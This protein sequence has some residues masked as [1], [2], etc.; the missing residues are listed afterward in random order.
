MLPV[1]VPFVLVSPPLKVAA[2]VKVL[3]PVTPNVP[4]TVPLPLIAKVPP[5]K[6]AVVVML[7]LVEIVP[8][9]VSI[10][11]AVRIPV[12]VMLPWT[13]VGNVCVK[14]GTLDPLV[15]RIELAAE[16]VA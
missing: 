15:A 5:C 16:A 2:P 4:P 7:L 12:E 1:K 10:E 14:P 9:P 13:A 3:V 6:V 8:K 11:P